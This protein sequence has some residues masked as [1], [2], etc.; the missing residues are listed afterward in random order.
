ML[1]D[2]VLLWKKIVMLS[3]IYTNKNDE[4]ALHTGTK[5]S[6]LWWLWRWWTPPPKRLLLCFVVAVLPDVKQNV[7]HVRFRLKS[8]VL[9]RV[10]ISGLNTKSLFI[11]PLHSVDLPSQQLMMLQNE[12][13]PH[14]TDEFRVLTEVMRCATSWKVPGSIPG[15][16]TGDFFRGIRQ[17]HVPGVNSALWNEYQDSPGGKDGRCVGL[18][19]LPP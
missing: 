4:H 16:D 2:G 18:T 12:P 13:H 1:V 17:V 10:E 15:R 19:T 3:P 14:L 9:W 5:P 7:T 8:A 11:R 6:A